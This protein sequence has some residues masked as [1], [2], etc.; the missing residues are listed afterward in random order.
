LQQRLEWYLIPAGIKFLRR[1][2]RMGIDMGLPT[3]PSHT[4]DNPGVS[5]QTLPAKEITVTVNKKHVSLYPGVD[6]RTGEQILTEV[7]T[8]KGQRSNE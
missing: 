8:F 6:E 1:S 4:A 7:Y 2:L 3:T 5:G